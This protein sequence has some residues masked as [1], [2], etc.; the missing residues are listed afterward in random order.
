MAAAAPQ[1]VNGLIRGLADDVPTG[2]LDRGYGA[3]V[4]LR[5]FG[6]H[7]ANQLLGEDF[8]LERIHPEN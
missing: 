8:D 5:A 3:H 1:I 6:V 7:I 4:N 2:D